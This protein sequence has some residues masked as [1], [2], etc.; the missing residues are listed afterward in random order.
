MTLATVALA[1]LMAVSAAAASADDYVTYQGDVGRSAFRPFADVVPP[2]EERWAIDLPIPLNNPSPGQALIAK[3]RVFVTA[4]Q[5]QGPP[6]RLYALDL[7]TGRT[8]WGPVFTGGDG[9]RS[10][11]AYEGGRVFVLTLT[12]DLTAWAAE[13]GALLWHVNV[14]GIIDDSPLLAAHG[15]VYV[16]LGSELHALDELDGHLLWSQPI[17]AFTTGGPVADDSGVY[18]AEDPNYAYKFT[19]DGAPVWSRVIDSFSGGGGRTPVLAGGRLYI[20]MASD[21]P[22]ILSA[23]SGTPLGTFADGRMPASDGTTT[24]YS[25]GMIFGAQT[26]VARDASTGG[27]RWRFAGNGRLMTAPMIVGDVVYVASWDGT[28]YALAL[29]DGSLLWSGDVGAG[30]NIAPPDEHNNGGPLQGLSAA[31]GRLIIPLFDQTGRKPARVLVAY[32]SIGAPPTSP[33]PDPPSATP[34]IAS[35]AP[36]TAPSPA[37]PASRPAT[38]ARRSAAARWHRVGRGL[39]LR[40]SRRARIVGPLRAPLLLT[41]VDL[42]CAARRA[43][44]VRARLG[45][46][47]ERTTLAAHASR[48]LEMRLTPARATR[49][50][51]ATRVTLSVSV[52]AGAPAAWIRATVA[53]HIRRAHARP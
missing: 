3:G 2:L 37:A 1:A 41:G 21:P 17:K 53:L 32:S 24:V 47:V 30:S 11:A 29:S 22:V 49:L 35:S 12:G 44:H 26:L 34:G 19:P 51:R 46:M 10:S 50:L 31:E 33:Q 5:W 36:S 27:E 52:R 6:C 48:P 28:L 18:V 25:E 23:D 40:R 39:F 43:C 15:H 13:S 20:P 16:N 14:G 7:E 4:G 8:L 45:P 42:R 9:H 38:S